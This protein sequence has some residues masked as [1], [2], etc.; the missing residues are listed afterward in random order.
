MKASVILFLLILLKSGS[1]SAQCF[2]S[3]PFFVESYDSLNPYTYL[4]NTSGSITLVANQLFFD[5]PSGSDYNRVYRFV[6]GLQAAS[7]NFTARCRFNLIDGNSPGH[8][9]MMFSNTS[10]DP[11]TSNLAAYPP[12]SN[13]ALGVTLLSPMLPTYDACC[14]NPFDQTNPWGFRLFAKNDMNLDVALHNQYIPMQYVGN[15]Y[16][17]ELQ[18]RSGNEISLSVYSDTGFTQEIPGSPICAQIDESFGVLNYLQQGVLTPSSWYRHIR[19]FVDDVRICANTPCDHCVS[20]V[21]E[22]TIPGNFQIYYNANEEMLLIR[23][24][25]LDDGEYTEI[26]IYSSS[27]SLCI[28]SKFPAQEQLNISIKQFGAGFYF[29]VVQSGNLRVSQKIVKF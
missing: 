13:S 5:N 8:M 25:D 29:A 6:P 4:Q 15:Y 27:G 22:Q 23:N 10:D 1:S 7:S 12:T 2:C 9:I 17:I 21:I 16:Y 11:H 24:H 18:R 3:Q 26:K 20:A 28:S 19:G 14:E